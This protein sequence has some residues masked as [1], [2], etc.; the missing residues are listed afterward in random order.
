[1]LELYWGYIG[2]MNE[3][4]EATIVFGRGFIRGCIRARLYRDKVFPQH[5]S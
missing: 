2:I 1:M 4:M 5:C 3:K